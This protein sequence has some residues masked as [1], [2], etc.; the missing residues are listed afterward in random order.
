MGKWKALSLL[1]FLG[2]GTG[3]QAQA[4]RST[5]PDLGCAELL[6]LKASFSSEKPLDVTSAFALHEDACERDGGCPY[7]DQFD[8]E[9]MVAFD[10]WKRAWVQ[11]QL[12]LK[13][14]PSTA[15]PR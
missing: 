5:M 2:L 15:N 11:E 9:A 4:A 8:P 14:C 3:L 1:I 13:G 12:E 6:A 7:P 10:T